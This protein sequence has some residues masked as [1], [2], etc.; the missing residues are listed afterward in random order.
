M[1]TQANH[2]KNTTY[3]VNF[4]IFEDLQDLKSKPRRP[5]NNGGKCGH[6]EKCEHFAV[7]YFFLE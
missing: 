5:G 1:E 6:F 3:M 7:K 2:D 4:G